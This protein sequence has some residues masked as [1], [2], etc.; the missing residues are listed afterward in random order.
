MM[1]KSVD[2]SG[3]K[4]TKQ[5][6]EDLLQRAHSLTAP[7][8]LRSNLHPHGRGKKSHGG[9]LLSHF[10]RSTWKTKKHSASLHK[11]TFSTI[12]YETVELL[13]V[14]PTDIDFS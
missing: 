12:H 9:T 4:Q 10:T 6:R 1:A 2:A 14:L 13:K 3:R 11:N 8:W 7:L 5:R